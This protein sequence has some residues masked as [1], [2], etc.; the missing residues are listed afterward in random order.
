MN[1]KIYSMIAVAALGLG[2]AACNDKWEPKLQEEGHLSLASLGLDVNTAE[3]VI[4]RAEGVDVSGFTV[5]IIN[6][7]EQV[8]GQ[9]IYS[10]MPEIVTLPVGEYTVKAYSHQVEKAAWDTPYYE[11]E[12]TLKIESNKIAEPQ[13]VVCRFA[14]VKVT[15]TF[16]ADL[17]KHLGDDY[18]VTVI[19]NDEGALEYLPGETRSGFFEALPQSNTLVATF[20]GTVDGVAE[21]IRKEYV[22]VA[23]GTHYQIRYSVKGGNPEIPDE[24]GEVDGSGIVVDASATDVNEG[25]EIEIEEDVIDEPGKRPGEDDGDEPGPGPDDPQGDEDITFTSSTLDLN[26]VNDPSAIDAAA[27]KIHSEKGFKHLNVKINSENA[28]F[29]ASVGSMMPSEFDLATG[30]APDGTDLTET[31]ESL[32]FEVGPYAADKKDV[33]FVITQF[34]APLSA[35]AFSPGV[36]TFSLEVVDNANASKTVDL[37]F[38]KAN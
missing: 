16:S 5:A 35:D 4:S 11:G 25:G 3:D 20:E 37:K 12:Q 14:S 34:L 9:W 6:S 19:A 38:E 22:D 28:A 1:T 32:G 29:M 10:E 7:D 21:T 8:A 18:K 15:V 2:L 36:H 24:S 31:L 26:G 33:E 30:K 13:T 23:P 27:V 17:L